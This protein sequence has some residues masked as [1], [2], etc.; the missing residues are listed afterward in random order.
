MTVQP[1]TAGR[2]MLDWSLSHKCIAIMLLQACVE[3]FFVV[4]KLYTLANPHV[5]HWVNLSAIHTHL[6]Y[7][8]LAC[9]MCLLLAVVSYA[10][11]N[12]PRIMCMMPFVC[13]WF[14]ALVMSYH[15]HLVGT[16]TPL[17]G[18]MLI[19][20][21]TLGLML[22]G[23]WVTYPAVL[24]A[25][26]L[27]GISTLMSVLHLAPYAPLFIEP[28]LPAPAQALSWLMSIMLFSTPL[29]LGIFLLLDHI[30][31]Q[32][33]K[34][35][36]EVWR[37]SQTDPL[38]GLYNRHFL[39]NALNAQAIKTSVV[40]MALLDIDHFKRINDQCGHLVGDQVLQDVAACL[41]QATRHTDWV[42][43]FGGEEFLIVMPN[44]TAEEALL[45][46]ER[47]RSNLQDIHVTSTHGETWSVSASF[48]LMTL[49]G[50][51]DVSNGLSEVD[52]LLYEA[53]RQGRNRVIYTNKTHAPNQEL[54]ASMG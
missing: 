43:R 36:A 35:A 41:K 18:V 4:W 5:S 51:F 46:M 24:F 14:I 17:T 8:I 16:L 30:I 45:A 33:K 38:T 15:A 37:L 19:G 27:L 26:V 47:C 54:S 42:G 3:G 49:T 31:E 12:H 52:K 20:L 34:N 13:A 50:P 53:K 6:P 32:W 11:A 29:V 44:T 48:G 10:L 23:R 25:V 7:S 22:F 21:S 39:S 40:S 9:A 2:F 1:H 28:V